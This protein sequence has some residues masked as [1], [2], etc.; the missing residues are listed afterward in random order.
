MSDLERYDI[1]CIRAGNPGPYTLS[2]TN[3]W[4]VGRDPAW[5]VDPGPLLEEHLKAVEREVTARGGAGGIAVTH[6]HPDHVEGLG[7][8][9]ERLG[10]PLDHGPL[11]AVALPGH[12]DDHVVFVW[13]HR[14]VFSGDAVLGEGSVFVT[15]RLG[16]Y[17]DGLRALLDRQLDLICPGHG[18]V[19]E[20]PHAKLRGYIAHREAREQ[21]LI[22]ALAGGLAT[23]DDLLDRVW[24]DAPAV[25]REA[26][27]V[28]LRAH[29]EKLGVRL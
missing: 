4:V 28:T 24:D 11:E 12:S 6:D 27:R 1:A 20:D 29:L 19:I 23:E 3:T 8:L 15:G 5:I 18:P 16:E 9:R 14:V 7:A 22:A 13:R 25:L 10:V 26:A 2:G 17:L 21:R